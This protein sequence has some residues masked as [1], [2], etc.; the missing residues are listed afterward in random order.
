VPV[1]ERIRDAMPDE[2][3][4]LESLLR[5]S[6]SIW[7]ADRGPLAGDPDDVEL[8]PDAIREQ[9]VRVAVGAN[10]RLVGFSVVLPT[11]KRVCEL[12]SLFVDPDFLRRGVGR[13]LMADVVERA[14]GEHAK[15][16][17]V[18]ADPRAAGFYERM[19]FRS[20]GQVTTW[21]GPALR[22]RVG[23]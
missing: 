13:S 21:S 8:A 19:G 11:R 15:R 2:V 16:L 5:R 20:A 6:S 1:V 14:R 4:V 9:R 7:E 12:D 17:D 18:I 23:L 10:E 22:M 3:E